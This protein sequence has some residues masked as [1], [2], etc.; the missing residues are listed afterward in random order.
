MT[1]PE[2]QRVVLQTIYEEFKPTGKWP[3]FQHLDIVLDQA[4]GLVVEPVL[5]SL[6]PALVRL[7]TPIRPHS[8]VTLRIAG[9]AHCG[10]SEEDLALFGQA[11]QWTVEKEREFRPASPY[12][13]EQQIVTSDEA[14]K[15]WREAGQEVSAL[16]LRKAYELLAVELLYEVQGSDG[17]SWQLTLSPRIRRFRGVRNYLE[18][19]RAIEADAPPQDAANPLVSPVAGSVFE[20]QS[21]H[22]LPGVR[23]AACE[24]ETGR[25]VAQASVTRHD[26]DVSLS[27]QTIAALAKPFHGGE[28]PSHSTIQLIWTSAG[29]EEYLG[30]GNKLD[31]VL[32]GLRALKDGRRAQQGAAALRPDHEKLRI[33]ASELATTLLAH[34]LVDEQ[35]IAEALESGPDA[36]NS[37][38]PSIPAS[39]RPGLD[40]ARASSSR[41]SA[42]EKADDPRAVMVVHG[43]DAPAR[44]AMFDWLRAVGLRPREWS[45]LV[46]A[47]NTAS[48]FIGEVLESAFRQAQ[49]VVVLFTPDEHVRLRASVAKNASGWRL[50]ARPNVL[51]EAGMAFATHPTRTVLVVLGDQDIPT[52][53]AGRNYVRLESA[54]QLRDLAQRLE[55]AGCPVD[56]TGDDWLDI[57]RFP[58]RSGFSVAPD[59]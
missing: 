7:Y 50:Q 18:Y 1:L 3:T 51:F 24:P 2:D 35:S 19:L 49:A 13:V 56:I 15:E 9:L 45:Q 47:S 26:G 25:A 39:P 27:S 55:Q 5:T 4:R 16:S 38:A 46:K 30:E 28:G 29:A 20:T 41:L 48:P 34:S 32:G 31:R 58:D 57:D 14:A 17:T 44:K 8:E 59:T 54:G 52:D 21:Q 6:R 43:R 33:V 36:K 40:D 23:R 22:E 53:L 12:Q 10:G 42:P 37:L 11:L